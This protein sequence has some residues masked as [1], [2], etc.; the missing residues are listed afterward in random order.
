MMNIPTRIS[1]AKSDYFMNRARD[2]CLSPPQ[3]AAD[4]KTTTI[5]DNYFSPMFLDA[6]I[7]TGLLFGGQ[8]KISRL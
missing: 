5:R 6:F 2:S 3:D 8:V 7:I 4:G 1:V